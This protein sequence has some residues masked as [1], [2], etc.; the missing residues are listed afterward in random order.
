MCSDECASRWELIRSRTYMVVIRP[1]RNAVDSE[2]CYEQYQK[3]HEAK[4]LWDEFLNSDDPLQF[5][6]ERLSAEDAARIG[7]GTE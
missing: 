2:P 4:A 5:I 1:A 3:L 7:D 6:A